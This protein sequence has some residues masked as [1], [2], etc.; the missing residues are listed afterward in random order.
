MASDDPWKFYTEGTV[1][2]TNEKTYWFENSLT[3]REVPLAIPILER[4]LGRKL[5]SFEF[6]LMFGRPFDGSI[7]ITIISILVS[8]PAEKSHLKSIRREVIGYVVRH[9]E[10]PSRVSYGA[11]IGTDGFFDI[12]G[13]LMGQLKV[14]RKQERPLATPFLDPIDLAGGALEKI[15]RN[16]AKAIFGSFRQAMVRV[17]QQLVARGA[18]SE[19]GKIKSLTE[20]ELAM[21]WGGGTTKP[22][23]KNQVDR[24][25]EILRHGD[26][27]HV[28]SIGQA[29]Q[30][31]GELGQLGVRSE[32]SSKFIPQRPA[33]GELP[34]SFRDG[35]GTYRMDPPHGPGTVPYHPHNEF[36]HINITLRNGRTLSV[37]VTGAKSF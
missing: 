36:P 14:T 12:D 13:K 2:H 19:V 32:S 20:E 37:I 35:P 33:S 16:G 22:L 3:G 24:A 34:G 5:R 7:N 17:E 15:V 11:I 25:I 30:I 27:V 31:Q 29:R 21:V 9:R 23:T 18:R 8:D 6:K 4:V 1:L 28:E 10:N 26:D